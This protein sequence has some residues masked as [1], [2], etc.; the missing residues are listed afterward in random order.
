MKATHNQANIVTTENIT[1]ATQ[2]I[3]ATEKITDVHVKTNLH[4]TEY[5]REE[6]GTHHM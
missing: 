6:V 4:D 5:Y 2:F 1:K 3:V